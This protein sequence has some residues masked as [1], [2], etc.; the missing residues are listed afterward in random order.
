MLPEQLEFR[1]E[2]FVGRFFKFLRQKLDEDFGES[3]LLRQQFL[4]RTDLRDSSIFYDN[5]IVNFRQISD[6]VRN[7]F[8]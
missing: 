3:A 4:V 1:G 6:A 7:L 8:N 2:I 5:N